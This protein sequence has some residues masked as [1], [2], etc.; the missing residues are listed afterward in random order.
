MTNTCVSV[1]DVVTFD[2]LGGCSFQNEKW[3]KVYACN[4]SNGKFRCGRPTTLFVADIAYITTCENGYILN[5]DT[6]F[7]EPPPSFCEQPSTNDAIF[8]AGEACDAQGG[9]FSF[10]CS[11]GNDAL[12]IPPSLDTTCNEP[13]DQC[14]MGFP[15]WPACM[16]DYDP[17]DPIDPPD[18]GFQNPDGSTSSSPDDGF[19][20]PDIDDVQPNESTDTAVLEAVKN[21]NRDQNEALTQISSDLNQGTSDIKNKLDDIRNTNAAIGQTIVDQMNQDY[22]IAE[23]NRLLQLQQNGTMANI[24][25]GI[26]DRIDQQGDS[27]TTAIGELASKGDETNDILNEINLKTCDPNLDMRFCEGEHNLTGNLVSNLVGDISEN[28]DELDTGSSNAIVSGAQSVI[29]DAGTGEMKGIIQG[30][31]S[32]MLNA[33]PSSGSCV[34]FSIPSLKGDI[35]FD[36]QFSEQF[37]LLAAFLLYIY[38]AWTLID[39]LLTGVTPVAGTVPYG[40]RR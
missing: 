28:M 1:G 34:P 22:Q 8:S 25:K 27:I 29:N 7:C 10:Q 16:G 40:S 6:G 35:N 13:P 36:C 2:V 38:T 14:V 30:N 3:G 24:G 5:P 31:I 11:N 12:G 9:V 21:M 15:N 18:G 39:I 23:A 4:V 19:N 20:K 33:F 26:S 17:T 32:S 37:K